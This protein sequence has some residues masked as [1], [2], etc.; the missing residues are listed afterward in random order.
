MAATRGLDRGRVVPE[1]VDAA[2]RQDL[3]DFVGVQQDAG[4][5][6]FSDGLLRWQ[7]IFRPLAKAA[8]LPA[9]TLTRWFDNNAFFRAPELDGALQRINDI[10]AIVPEPDV[11]MPRVA[12]LPSPYLFSRAAVTSRERNAL[13]LDI[14]QNLLRPAAEQLAAAGCRIVHLEEP[15]LGFLGIDPGDRAPLERAL[16]AIATGL[17]ADVVFHVYFGDAAAHLD[18]LR[19]L[20]VRAVGVDLVETD[21]TSLTG[22]WDIGLLAGCLDGRSSVLESEERTVDVLRHIAERVQP[23]VLYVST[24][25]ELEFL[26]R[27][28]AAEKVRLLGAVVRQLG[29]AARC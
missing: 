14:A 5:D 28:V 2:Y 15:W 23:P 17:D 29:R 22:S 1:Q 4:L 13:M 18:W 6:L 12:T 27:D 20:P 21:V 7:D 11:P 9:R 16:D 3:S 19:R 25:C 10:A 24:S 26:P 8:G